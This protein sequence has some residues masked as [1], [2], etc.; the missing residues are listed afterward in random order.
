M[1]CTN[2]SNITNSPWILAQPEI[3]IKLH[4]NRREIDEAVSINKYVNEYIKNSHYSFLQI[5]T[6]G[7]KSI[8][9]GRTETAFYVPEFKVRKAGRITDGT[10]VYTAEMTEILMPLDW[11]YDVGPDKVIQGS[12]LTFCT[13]CTGAPNFFS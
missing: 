4:E 11:V 13:G 1:I 7:T 9:T 6:D 5:Y 8:D 3:D 10:S 12:R 2:S